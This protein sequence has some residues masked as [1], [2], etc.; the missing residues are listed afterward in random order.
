MC[1]RHQLRKSRRLIFSQISCVLAIYFQGFG[2]STVGL[3]CP[4]EP[5]GV[6]F[7]IPS[8]FDSR[9]YPMPR[10]APKLN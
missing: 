7:K 3:I 10:R 9:I 2:L 5:N 8:P 1:T 4:S 6:T